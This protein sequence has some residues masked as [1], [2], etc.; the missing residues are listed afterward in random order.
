MEMIFWKE[1]Q[2]ESKGGIYF[3]SDIK[4]AIKMVIESGNEPVGIRI[5]PKDYT[6]E[7]LVKVQEPKNQ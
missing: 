2:Y 4:E 1:G 7:I 5:D 3:R 6:I